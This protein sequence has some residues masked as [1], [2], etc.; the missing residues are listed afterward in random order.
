M[1]MILAANKRTLRFFDSCLQSPQRVAADLPLKR[2]LRWASSARRGAS[3]GS[4]RLKLRIS[5]S[6]NSSDHPGVARGS[7]ER[8]RSGSMKS[9]VEGFR[10]TKGRQ[11][12]TVH[13]L[14]QRLKSRLHTENRST[15]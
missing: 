15:K 3:F 5:F 14:V 4:C 2:L 8:E 9:Y 7:V 6:E 10:V 12:Y 13:A 1:T 11:I